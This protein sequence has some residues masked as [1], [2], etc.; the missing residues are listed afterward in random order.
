MTAFPDSRIACV[1]QCWTFAVAW[2][3]VSVVPANLAPLA[4]GV[5]S[6]A[7]LTAMLSAAMWALGIDRV[8]TDLE[9]RLT[10]MLLF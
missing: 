6:I 5:P 8:V 7:N 4:A 3:G 10:H 1:S 9:K 2:G